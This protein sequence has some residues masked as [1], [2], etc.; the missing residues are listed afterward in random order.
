MNILFIKHFFVGFMVSEIPRSVF[1][2]CPY[3]V[4]FPYKGVSLTSNICIEIQ[5]LSIC[6]TYNFLGVILDTK[7]E[8]KQH[9]ISIQIKL[10]TIIYMLKKL[11]TILPKKIFYLLYNSLFL[12]H[13]LYCL[14]LWGNVYFSNIYEIELLQKK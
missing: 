1:G 12:P 14:K 4:T 10:S 2:H 6:K 9:I 3:S 11:C 7:L 13:V 5:Q 8:F